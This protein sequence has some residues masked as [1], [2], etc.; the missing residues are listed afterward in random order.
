MP[1]E[2][3]YD[4][5]IILNGGDNFPL[6]VDYIG[7]ARSLLWHRFCS[8]SL[9]VDVLLFPDSVFKKEITE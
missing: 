4:Y 8:C 7:N 2:D 6:W 3:K 9:F 1:A 5:E